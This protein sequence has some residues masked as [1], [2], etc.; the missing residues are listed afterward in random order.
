MD[1]EDYKKWTQIF[2]DLSLLPTK[3]SLA[4][5]DISEEFHVRPEK[6]KVLII[7]IKLLLAIRPL[8]DQPGYR[9]VFL[10]H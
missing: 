2:G 1:F 5:P 3:Y 9:G 10:R 4:K 6:A 8:L 7:I